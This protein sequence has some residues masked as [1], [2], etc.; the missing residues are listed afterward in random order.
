MSRKR[1]RKR[2]HRKCNPNSKYSKKKIKSVYR[3]PLK[4]R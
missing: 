2:P 3:S 1:L 4:W